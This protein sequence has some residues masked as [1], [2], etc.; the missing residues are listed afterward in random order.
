MSGTYERP[1]GR[2]EQDTAPVMA[3]TPQDVEVL[4]EG[5]ESKHPLPDVDGQGDH[6]ICCLLSSS[7]CLSWHLLSCIIVFVCAFVCVLLCV[8]CVCGLCVWF[9]CVVRVLCVLV[10]GLCVV[11][12]CAVCVCV[13]CVRFVCA[14]R[15]CVSHKH[16]HKHTHTASGLPFLPAVLLLVRGPLVPSLDAR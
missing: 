10:C 5:K 7:S 2:G 15:V 14:F 12:V 1:S 16:T 4:A 13:M 8:V 3:D 11:C 6:D 9:V